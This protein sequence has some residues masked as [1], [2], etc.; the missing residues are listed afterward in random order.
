MFNR[1][2][3]DIVHRLDPVMAF[4]FAA[5]VA[6]L[7]DDL[8]WANEPIH[9]PER[10][11]AVF[12]ATRSA[13]TTRVVD[14]GGGFEVEDHKVMTERL[15][16]PVD[17]AALLRDHADDVRSANRVTKPTDAQVDELV[18]MLRATLEL[19]RDYLRERRRDYR[20]LIEVKGAD[21][22]IAIVKAGRDIRIDAAPAPVDRGRYDVIFTTRFQYLRRSLSAPSGVRGA[23]R[24][25]G[26]HFTYRD[27]RD[28]RVNLHRELAVMLRQHTAPP[29][30][31]FGGQPEWLYRAKR[32]ARRMI[33][34]NWPDLY[35]LATRVVFEGQPAPQVR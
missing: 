1:R 13:A 25:L 18:A 31:R 6:F 34:G 15:F 33:G 17:N 10:P 21:T 8:A 19:T 28:A 29:P 9:D 35:D 26:R 5:D 27:A 22:A 2:W 24:R 32:F 7:D 4:P 14:I 30:A 20:F 3:V 23:V 12:E 16:V 11:T